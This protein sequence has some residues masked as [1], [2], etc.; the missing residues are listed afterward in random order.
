MHAAVDAAGGAGAE[1]RPGALNLAAPLADGERVYVP[2]VGESPPPAP[3]PAPSAAGTAPPGPVDLNRA[4]ADQLDALPG[5]GPATAAGDRR[6]PRAQRPVRLGRRPRGVRGIGPAKLEAIRGAGDGVM[7]RVRSDERVADGEPGDQQGGDGAEPDAAGQPGVR[8][9]E[10][11]PR[12]HRVARRPAG[13][14][15]ADDQPEHRR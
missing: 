5:I 1:R 15:G 3:P 2:V 7:R 11:G 10:V 13:G 8:A 6:P 9:P 14:D 4:T 12:R